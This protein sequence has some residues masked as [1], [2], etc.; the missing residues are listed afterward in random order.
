MRYACSPN[1]PNRRHMTGTRKHE[2]LVRLDRILRQAATR[3]TPAYV[4]RLR[5][6]VRRVETLLEMTAAV[7][8]R[9][10]EKLHKALKRLRRR[11]GKLRD[12]DVQIAALKSVEVDRGARER[13]ELL[14]VLGAQRARRERKIA[15]AVERFHAAALRKAFQSATAAGSAPPAGDPALL[16]QALGRFAELAS[17][18]STLTEKNAHEFRTRCKRVR[19]RAELAGDNEAAHLAVEELKKIQDAIGGWHDWVLLSATAAKVLEEGELNS[20]LLLTIGSMRRARFA[21][22]QRTVTEARRAL[23]ELRE[24]VRARQPKPAQ[25]DSAGRAA[26]AAG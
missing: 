24:R 20:P 18:Y 14:G 8:A 2:L 19:Y 3:P 13:A 11:A 17:E 1:P 5:T 22:V 21:Q 23:L 10:R 6:T 12:V 25:A 4:H 16:P 7:P 15:R 26:R 9:R